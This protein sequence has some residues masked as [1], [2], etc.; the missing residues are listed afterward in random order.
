[1]ARN[2]LLPGSVDPAEG[3]SCNLE[4]L[5]GM[6][7]VGKVPFSIRWS[8]HLELSSAFPRIFADVSSVIPETLSPVCVVRIK[9]LAGKVNACF[10][11]HPRL[12]A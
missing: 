12:I 6:A 5:L 3:T 8:L 9:E 7:A 1:V 11:I 4:Y 10:Q 2:L